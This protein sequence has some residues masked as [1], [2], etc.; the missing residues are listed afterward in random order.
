MEESWWDLVVS[1]YV[2]FAD[3]F[4]GQTAKRGARQETRPGAYLNARD[5]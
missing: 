1:L 2:V 5:H 4:L 3:S